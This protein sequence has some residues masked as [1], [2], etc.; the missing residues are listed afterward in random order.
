MTEKILQFGTGRF[1]RAFA[2]SLIDE[3]NRSGRYNGRIVMVAS[4]PSG[5][6]ELLNQQKG[7]YTL[8]TRGYQQNERMDNLHSVTAVSHALSASSHWNQIL[9]LAKSPHLEVVLSNTTEIGLS[10]HHN[11]PQS[12][13]QSFPGRLCALLH[14]RAEFFHYTDSS[15]IVILPCELID[16]NGDILR[17]L[18]IKQ[19]QRW[20]LGARFIDWIQHSIPFC[21]TLVDRIVPGLPEKAELETA[22]ARIGYR[23]ELLTVCEPYRLWAIQE[24]ETLHEELGFSRGA[25]GIVITPDISPYRTRKIRLLNGGH[26]LSVPIGLLAGCETVLDSMTHPAVRTFIESLLRDEIGPVLPVDPATVDPYIDEVLWRWKNPYMYH[27]LID[28]TLQSTTKL[29]HRAVPTLMDYYQKHPNG[30]APRRIALGFAAWLRFM[31][32]TSTSDGTVYGR[33]RGKT[34]PI[35][36][37]HAEL[38]LD[39]WPKKDT[40]IPGFVQEVL[41]SQNLWGVSL[42]DCPGFTK[43]VQTSLQAILEQDIETVLTGTQKPQ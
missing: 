16:N 31:R 40:L 43:T 9:T 25:D 28:I 19:A 41:S 4:T 15:R 10:L 27:R 22:Y 17:D 36:D 23:D 2:D 42:N 13:P 35:H 32:G 30:P 38:F 11:D 33:L 12:S 20:H 6:A 29:R 7:R 39:W 3:A 24:E 37:D 8:W 21:N 34:Y 14:T 1:L 5:R 18:V 26:T